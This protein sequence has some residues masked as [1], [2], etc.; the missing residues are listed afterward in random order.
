MPSPATE[1]DVDGVM[2]RLT[3]P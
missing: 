1:L 2:V 3:N